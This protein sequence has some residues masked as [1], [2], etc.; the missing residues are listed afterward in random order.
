MERSNMSGYTA[1]EAD[2]IF[3]PIKDC[4]AKRYLLLNN[5]IIENISDSLP[6]H[7]GMRHLDFTGFTVT[8]FF[9]DYHLHFSQECSGIFWRNSRNVASIWY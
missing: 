4:T 1:I 2:H 3:S 5:G 6:V 7:Q 9:C 8:P